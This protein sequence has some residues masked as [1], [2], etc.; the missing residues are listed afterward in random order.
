MLRN[1][2]CWPVELVAGLAG[3]SVAAFLGGLIGSV[4]SANQDMGGLAGTMT[5]IMLAFPFGVGAGGGFSAYRQHHH[6][7]PWLGVVG[8][9]LGISLVAL[10]AEPTGL[11]RKTG[12]LLVVAAAACCLSARAAVHLPRKF[13]Q[14]D[15]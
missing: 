3:G 10:I 7:R 4:L 11:N 12:L 9:I 13:T 14:S 5:G 1:K 2:R 15:H 8:A 6:K